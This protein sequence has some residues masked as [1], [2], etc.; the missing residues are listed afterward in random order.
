[1]QNKRN[2]FRR[3]ANSPEFRKWLYLEA[4]R[5]LGIEAEIENRVKEAMDSRNIRVERWNSQARQWEK[6]DAE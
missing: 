3:L 1:M 4:A 2:A 5:R 6:I